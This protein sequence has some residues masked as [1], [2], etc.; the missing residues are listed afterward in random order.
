MEIIVEEKLIDRA[1]R[2]A[3]LLCAAILLSA[4]F[5]ASAPANYLMLIISGS[6]GDSL[7][8]HP[9]RNEKPVT[10]EGNMEDALPPFH[11]ALAVPL[12]HPLRVPAC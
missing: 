8:F 5:L 6:F 12:P 9:D 2:V 10:H 11:G 3:M 4:S 7:P 1:A